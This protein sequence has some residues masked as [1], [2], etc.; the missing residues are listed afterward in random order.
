M[1]E[2]GRICVVYVPFLVAILPWFPVAT[3]TEGARPWCRARRLLASY[4]RVMSVERDE[5]ARLVREIPDEEVPQVLAELRR[6]VR[7]SGERSWPP[8]WFSVA[9]GDGTAVGARSEDLLAE[10]FGQ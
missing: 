10:G 5:L 7:S 8:A 6:Y 3:G 9:P 1:R 4:T 2:R